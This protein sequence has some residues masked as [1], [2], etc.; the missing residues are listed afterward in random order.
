MHTCAALSVRIVSDDSWRR[1]LCLECGSRLMGLDAWKGH[2]TRHGWGSEWF[3]ARVR[4]ALPGERVQVSPQSFTTDPTALEVRTVD[5]T[6]WKAGIP[7]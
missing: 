6:T 3:A 2:R 5:D 7:A 4:A 1:E